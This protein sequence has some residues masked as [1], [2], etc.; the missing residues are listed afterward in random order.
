MK[1]ISWLVGFLALALVIPPA[2]AA[3]AGSEQSSLAPLQFLLGDW[4]AVSKPGDPTGWSSF[5]SDLGGRVIVRRNRAEYPASKGRPAAV[6]EDLLVVYREGA[7]AVIR[8][9]YIDTEGH[10]IRYTAEAPAEGHVVFVSEAAADAPRYRLT[11]TKLSDGVLDGRFD[12]A[13][14]GKPEAFAT[15]LQWQARKRSPGPAAKP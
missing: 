9:I 6:H 13:P 2:G 10:V 4:D 12:V 14:A 5:T 1:G 3:G 8:A 11:Y 7:P 15:Y